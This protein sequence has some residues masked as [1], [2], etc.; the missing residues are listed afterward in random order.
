MYKTIKGAIMECRKVYLVLTRTNTF[1]SRLIGFIKDDE[2]KYSIHIFESWR[3]NC[4]L[5]S[6]E[7]ASSTGREKVKPSSIICS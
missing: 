7:S 3:T 6:R 2:Y 5:S 4:K 1:L